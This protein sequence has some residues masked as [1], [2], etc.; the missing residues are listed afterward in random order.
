VELP[1]RAAGAR[2][3]HPIRR[4]DPIPSPDLA[5]RIPGP[6]ALKVQSCRR[7][8]S[9]AA[10]LYRHRALRAFASSPSSPHADYSSTNSPSYVALVFGSHWLWHRRV[11]RPCAS[12]SPPRGCVGQDTDLPGVA[13]RIRLQFPAALPRFAALLLVGGI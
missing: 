12:L 1:C 2:P 11:L 8:H 4:S 9:S 13:S 7:R 3:G 6:V 10:T 5:P